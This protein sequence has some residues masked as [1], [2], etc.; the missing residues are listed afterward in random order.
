MMLVKLDPDHRGRRTTH[1]CEVNAVA[2]H[3]EIAHPCSSSSPRKKA[4]EVERCTEIGCNAHG[5]RPGTQ[6]LDRLWKILSMCSGGP[7]RLNCAYARA[8]EVQPLR[9]GEVRSTATLP[10]LGRLQVGQQFS[11]L[12]EDLFKAKTGNGGTSRHGP[13]EIRCH[14][15]VGSTGPVHL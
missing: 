9:K 10:L 3:Q 13:R 11:S 14:K 2:K 5:S 12:S 4:F 1:Q 6:L 8:S 15:G 7:A